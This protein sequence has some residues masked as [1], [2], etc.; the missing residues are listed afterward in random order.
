MLEMKIVSLKSFKVVGFE[1]VTTTQDGKNPVDCPTVWERFFKT[2]QN[3]KDSD[4]LKES[5]K[6]FKSY[7][8]CQS[9][10]ND[11]VHFRYIAGIEY[12]PTDK[13]PEGMK[14]YEIPSSRYA[15]FIHLGDVSTVAKTF[16][17]IY[18]NW[19]TITKEKRNG[20]Y[21]FELYDQDFKLGDPECKTYLYFPIQ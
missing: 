8:L 14:L 4:F 11:N 2:V 12:K 18:T 15:V 3:T 16:Q 19:D 20:D 9:I 17:S 21:D 13:I 6:E 10:K 1:V 7:G 5:R